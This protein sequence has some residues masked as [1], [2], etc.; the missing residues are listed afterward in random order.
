[1]SKQFSE[2]SVSNS[3]IVTVV[4]R[5]LKMI[6]DNTDHIYIP[7]SP[8]YTDLLTAIEEALNSPQ[9]NIPISDIDTPNYTSQP[10]QTK[11]YQNTQYLKAIVAT[12][13]QA[14]NDNPLGMTI[15]SALE[16]IMRYKFRSSLQTLSSFIVDSLTV[17][18]YGFTVNYIKKLII[19]NRGTTNVYLSENNIVNLNDWMKVEANE[20]VVFEELYIPTQQLFFIAESGSTR[21][22]IQMINP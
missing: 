6:K 9:P 1:M 14:T 15:M 7:P 16:T 17:Y 20:K 21:V 11:Q 5:L 22:S 8:D 18:T 3:E 4:E 13:G 12:I 2:L 10:I 19:H